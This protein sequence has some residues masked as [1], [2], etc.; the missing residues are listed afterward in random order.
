MGG[1]FYNL[2]SVRTPGLHIR[3]GTL[4]AFTRAVATVLICCLVETTT[5]SPIRRMPMGK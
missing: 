1:R 4:G 3:N 2:D 5:T